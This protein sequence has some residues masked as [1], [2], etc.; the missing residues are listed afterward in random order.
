MINI[1]VIGAGNWGKNLV[2]VFG[3]NSSVNLKYIVDTDKEALKKFSSPAIKTTDY[4]IALSDTEIDAFIISTPA[5]THYEIAW[6]ALSAGKHVFVEKP[7]TIEPGQSEELIRLSTKKNLKLMV[8]HLL[9]YHP[10][11]V[12]M[13][14]YISE[15]ELGDIYYIYCQRLNLGKIRRDENVL[16]SFAPHDI[17]IILHLLGQNPESVSARGESYLQNGIED[18]VFLNMKF[19]D[20]KIANIHVSWLDPHKVRRTTVV[21]SK[22]MM[23][24]DDME[25][26]EKLR[27]YDKGFEISS[28]SYNSYGEFLSLRDGNIFIPDI[29]IIEPLLLECNHFIECIEKN[30]T[31]LSDGNNGLAV[32]KILDSAQKSLKN[33]GM[34]VDL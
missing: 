6:E 28:S 4:K 21:G 29:K 13:K 16:L 33:G 20:K 12:T 19:R 3:E 15:N 31:P 25:P 34:Q 11:M 7:M 2:R 14:N 23:V 5:V 24:F 18:V 1:A 30:M 32:I 8:G 17:Y 27:I 9:L 26:R 22:K 10:C